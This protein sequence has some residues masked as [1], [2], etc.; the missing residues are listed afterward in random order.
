MSS[1]RQWFT[2]GFGSAIRETASGQRL[3][4]ARKQRLPPAKAGCDARQAS[5][6]ALQPSDVHATTHGQADHQRRERAAQTADDVGGADVR[7][8]RAL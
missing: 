6:V 3:R 1:E 5:G 4:R 2:G 7:P 8:A